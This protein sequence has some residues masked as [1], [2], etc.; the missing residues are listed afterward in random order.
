[1]HHTKGC[2][3]PD[4]HN[5]VSYVKLLRLLERLDIRPPSLL[6]EQ[7]AYEN[8]MDHRAGSA[9][10]PSAN[11]GAQVR[12]LT[13]K[14]IHDKNIIILLCPQTWSR[15]SSVSIATC[16]ALDGLGIESRWGWDF[17]HKPNR[18]WDPPS[19]LHNVCR[20]FPGGKSAG[21]WRLPPTPS[22]AKDKERVQLYL[23]SVSGPSRC[24]LG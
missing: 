1:M 21:S 6:W 23:Y 7:P 19:L 20:I 2:L 8:A 17:S 12:L 14:Q 24:V 22:S 9:I 18:R 4:D 10:C 13:S 15:D 5:F 3:I 16:Y 11:G